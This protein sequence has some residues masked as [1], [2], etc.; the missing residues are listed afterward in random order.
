MAE[1]RVGQQTIVFRNPP[2]IISSFATVGPDE[3]KGPLA[4]YFNDILEDPM[5]GQKTAEKAELKM[6][7]STIEQT[8]AQAKLKK[9]EIHYY[10]SG[11]LLNQIISSSFSARTLGVPFIG[12]YGACSSYAE[13]LGLGSVL[14]DGSYAD[15]VLVATTSHYQTAERQFRYPIE[16]NIQRKTSNQVTVTGA[17]VSILANAGDGIKV[18]HATFGK[19]IDMG[20][21]DVNDMGSAMAPAAVDTLVQHLQDTNR[22]VADYDLILTGDLASQGKKMFGLLAKEKGISLGNKHQDA[23]DLIFSPQQDVGAGAS[24]CACAAVVTIG[25]VMKEMYQGRFRRVLLIA[26]G[27]LM[28]ALTFQQGE[29]IPGIGHAIVLE[30]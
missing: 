28:N 8:L 11:D 15:K 1:N 7:E 16:L 14:I 29:S 17:G 2:R 20:L 27:A 25:Y 18:T 19:V 13:G 6:L 23:G 4:Q 5:L 26:T 3:G 21:K 24:G 10:I 22:S 30:V 9:E 12:I